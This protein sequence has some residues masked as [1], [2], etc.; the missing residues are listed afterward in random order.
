MKRC[1]FALLA[2]PLGAYAQPAV[3]TYHNDGSRT[4]AN[5]Q[6]TVLNTSSV[7]VSGFG[8][9][10][11]R[12][13][14]DQLY[15]QLLYV[16]NVNIP[17]RGTHNVLYAATVND[18]VYAFDADYADLTGP[19]W[20]RSFLSPG[21]VAINHADLS[22]AGS[23]G[24]NYNDFSG[25][26]GIVGTPVI[27]P[28]P[29][30][31]APAGD[32]GT[33]YVVA[34]TKE[35]GQ[36]FQ[37][38]HALN[39]QTGEERPNSPVLITATVAGTGAGSVNGNITFNTLTQNQRPGLA[40]VNGIVYIGWASHCDLG[41]YHGW[42]MGYDATTLQQLTVF[43]DTP[44]GS[45][46]G[47]WMGGSPP[48]FDE[49]G[50][51][52]LSTGNGTIGANGNP[53]D[54]RNRG[55]SF[56]K[57]TPSGSTM[58]VTSF[59]TPFNWS[60]LEGGD[61]DLGSA[62]L[63][64]APGAGNTKLAIGAGKQGRLY[65]VDRDNMGGLQAGSDSQ[66]IQSVDVNL[67]KKIMGGPVYWEGPGGVRKFYVWAADTPL[68]AYTFV[69]SGFNVTP[70]NS[71]MTVFN[72]G[73]MLSISANGNTAGTGIV[74][75]MCPTN[76]ANQ[77]VVVGVLRALNAE[78]ITQELWNSTQNSA[79]DAIGNYA[80]FNQ[81]TVTNGRVYVPTFSNKILVY[82]GIQTPVVPAAPSSLASSAVS[83]TQVHLE[84]VDNDNNEA[85]YVIERSTDGTNFDQIMNLPADTTSYED[86]TVTRF[87][88]YTY[89]VRAITLTS[90]AVSNVTAVATDGGDPEPVITVLGG[91]LPI[92]PGATTTS[93]GNGTAFAQ[94]LVGDSD[95]AH[96]FTIT[97]TGNA[98]LN[99]AGSPAVT[100]GGTNAS[101]F[102]VSVAPATPVQ[103]SGTTTFQ[104]VFTPSAAGTRTAVVTIAND[105]PQSGSYSF[106]VSGEGTLQNLL[107]WWRFNESDG[108]AASDN[109][110]G[111]GLGSLTAPLPT[112]TNAG[113]LDG[114]ITFS[115]VI[116]QSVTVNDA[117]I[118][119]PTSGITISSWIY[120]TAWNSGA[121]ARIMQKGASDNQYRLLVENG[122][123]KFHAAGV[124]TLTNATLPAL[125]TWTHVAGTYDGNTMR[126]YYN[127]VVVASAAAT[128]PISTTGDPLYIGTKSAV[129]GA[130]NHF[131]G[132]I[133]DV[134]LFGRGL[135][136]SEIQTLAAQA[137]T[138]SV[139]ATT[140]TAQKGTGIN[141]L[142]TFTRTTG[143]SG[144]LNVS[145][146]LLPGLNQAIYRTDFGMS[147]IP[148]AL[149]I[150]SGQGTLAMAVTPLEFNSVTGTVDVTVKV[151]D[152]PGYAAGQ[153]DTAVVH[154]LDSPVNLWKISHFGSIANANLPQAAD[155]A[156]YNGDGVPNLVKY[157]LGQDPTAATY[158]QSTSAATETIDGADYLTLTFVRPKPTPAG[159]SYIPESRPD[160]LLGAW[161]SA[162]VISGYP[163]DN[164]DGTETVKVRTP[165]PVSE[166]DRGFLRLRI[167]RP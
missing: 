142:F 117:P 107:G 17:G 91:G 27:D 145:F 72:P 161:D 119:N 135:S 73:A 113:K 143:T 164:G 154:I 129:A 46:G 158:P 63:L 11:S 23:C 31:G 74:W 55:E 118:L 130:G 53:S 94:V 78:N 86:T 39:V 34:R 101:D 62:G 58:A 12:A 97:N 160:L 38:L 29:F 28:N 56:L 138:V 106:A 137:G 52:F 5:L 141:G 18:T 64:L 128:G 88:T 162:P 13:V 102:S 30:P 76:D 120:P 115:G 48:S 140:A 131:I 42:M 92:V 61:V 7:N 144:N 1:A 14:D 45:N 95:T 4:G 59:F 85:G 15:S 90:S 49:Q 25:N 112:W 147:E 114:A 132:R 16:P 155:D 65:V 57:L 44:D 124:G 109:S 41:P 122:V 96:T 89:R 50:N 103:A 79:R 156:A 35:N 83:K 133:D 105:D 9:I 43:N 152:G 68:K 99:L 21:V 166:S 69:G 77:H 108:T 10:Y 148:P 6:E 8:K 82:G 121:N 163:I 37:R 32:Q 125:N 80:K 3:L 104:V 66:I 70:Q 36:F 26:M 139:V 153:N 98:A 111:G 40:L 167:A 146:D 87:V 151:V 123:F 165:S 75:A 149:I 67:N 54:T 100:I 51:L 150:P 81:V 24:G 136:T 157:A 93:G 127:G 116:G 20:T 71:T 110:G 2:L 60:T 134:K 33:L 19:L 159:V 47:I 84:W 22:A 126:L